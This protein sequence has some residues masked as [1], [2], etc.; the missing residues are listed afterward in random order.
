MAAVAVQSSARE[1]EPVIPYAEMATMDAEARAI[2]ETAAELLGVTPNAGRTYGHR[3]DIAKLIHSMYMTIMRSEQSGL[4]VLL[5][6]KLGLICSSINGCVYCRSHQCSLSQ[7]SK[8][9]DGSQWGLSDQELLAI[10]SGEDEGRDDVERLCF[11]FARTASRSPTEVGVDL[12]ERLK[13]RLSAAQIVELGCVV[14][15][16]KFFNTMHDSLHIPSEA[17]MSKYAGFV[18]AGRP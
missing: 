14:A 18:D 1:A 2:L 3:P 9:R 5:K 16:W 7:N 11:E 17:V 4:D 8:Q 13:I 6:V 15:M 10:I 12:L